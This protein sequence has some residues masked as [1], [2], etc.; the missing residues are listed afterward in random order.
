MEEGKASCSPDCAD[1]RG[2]AGHKLGNREE[3]PKFLLERPGEKRTLKCGEAD[4][5]W[6]GTRFLCVLTSVLET[7]ERK[8]IE[9]KALGQCGSASKT[10]LQNRTSWLHLPHQDPVDQAAQHHLG[11]EPGSTHRLEHG[12]SNGGGVC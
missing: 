4:I 3:K 10:S 5:V 7:M 11:Q 2:A 9:G 6:K 8:T 1:L 12:R